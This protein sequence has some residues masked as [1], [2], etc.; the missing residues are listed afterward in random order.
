M[1]VCLKIFGL[2]RQGKPNINAGRAVPPVVANFRSKSRLKID[3]LA[4]LKWFL[5][6]KD[7]LLC[8]PLAVSR[9]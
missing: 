5:N 9:L 1:D 6:E 7:E 2:T 4:T 3:Q 8:F